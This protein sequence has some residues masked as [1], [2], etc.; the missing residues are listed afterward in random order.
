M[1]RALAAVTLASGA[2]ALCFETLWF[3]QA[4]LAFGSSAWAT[5][6]VLASFMAGLGLGN[7][8]AARHVARL[9]RPLRAYAWLELAIAAS[10][11]A[12]VFGLP[13]LGAWLAPLWRLLLEEPALLQAL[14][15][16]I[17][18]AAL[19]LPAT[20]MGA[21]L[22]VLIHALGARDPSFGSALGRIYG[23]N[24][25]GAV[26]GAVAGEAF[27]L[28]PLGMRGT[29]LAAAGANLAAAGGALALAA[30]SGAGSAPAASLPHARAG[31]PRS[32]RSLRLLAASFVAGALMLA[33]ESAWLR[34][35][36]LFL[37]N[38]SLSF[39]LVL[40]A[41]LAGIGL[42]GRAAG[43]WLRRR[44]DAAAR[45]AEVALLTGTASALGL[46][47]FA[48]AAG[49]HPQGAS[50]VGSTLLLAGLLGFPA[51]LL[52]GALFPLTGAL[53]ARGLGPPG[54]AA[55]WLT[56]ANTAGSA[57]GGLAG[58]L[59]LIPALG[60]DRV[61]QLLTAL[62]AVAA[63]LLWQKSRAPRA[64]LS[65]ALVA[66]AFAL[67]V[68]G[69]PGDSIAR[70]YAPL[71]E[72]RFE[73]FGSGRLAALREGRTETAM[74]LRSERLGETESWRL[75]TNGFGM[76]STRVPARRY[77][78]LFAWLPA[79]FHPA[80]RRALLISYG[81]GNSARA[82][83]G[84]PELAA[85]DVV[86]ISED[87]LAFAD[88][89]HGADQNPLRDPRVRVHVEDGRFFLL[90]REQSFDLITAEPPP[91]KHAG[92]GAL[93][94]RECFERIRDRLAAGGIA[95]WWLP[96]HQLF[97]DETRS[98][99][100]AWC[101]VFPDCTLWTGADLNWM[102]VGSRGADWQPS[103]AQLS[104]LWRQPALAA[105][106]R[107]LGL[108]APAQLA[109]LFL[110]DADQIAAWSAGA[111]PFVDD[112]PGRIDASLDA[113]R[114]DAEHRAPMELAGRR[115][116]FG[117]SRFARR[118]WP[119]GLVRAAE[120]ALRAERWVE[121][122]WGIG[123]APL[124]P[125]QRLEATDRLLRE[126]QLRTPILW[127]WGLD[128]DALRALAGA[129]A[130]GRESPEQDFAAGVQALAERRDAEAAR[131][132]ERAAL[133]RARELSQALA[134]YASCRA[135]E[136]A[137]ARAIG[138]SELAG[139]GPGAG[140]VLEWLARRCGIELPELTGPRF[141]SP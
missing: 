116:R 81:I 9:R 10:G 99:L 16:A 4:S 109:A 13:Q 90:A 31:S 97:W 6:L 106:L 62:Y 43:A 25:L 2:A 21:T 130:A 64:R 35:L 134:V 96:V 37:E 125:L 36:A 121:G 63:L 55:G 8:I 14:R 41:V 34:L 76:A 102:L 44:P 127:W 57:L 126:T 28:A 48:R 49:S 114:M 94:S 101:D 82:L 135:G 69:L 61:F 20:A 111:P 30:R 132:L 87:V 124:T 79:A 72:S 53:L 56:L 58:A 117:E 45:A 66:G 105:E 74:L 54:R 84:I 70:R 91:P 136:L 122:S 86:D 3:R 78:K 52:S 71:I 141:P 65:R 29:A 131:L 110:A 83:V 123:A 88:E 115:Q 11:I 1:L 46:A 38:N 103:E 18:F 19:L 139:A 133:P 75:V 112:D 60:L 129:R 51:A 137:R 100:R 22:P 85:L 119:P 26:L 113:A 95:S 59:W 47:L 93:Y 80:P 32:A 5:S 67:A 138:R 98:I 128:D 40:A 140:P 77:M 107:A 12:I 104:R 23:W 39:A 15:F 120:E 24:T 68:A 89:V 17:A 92:V 7:A 42:G 73:R 27:L 108:E 118:A 33:F 50:G